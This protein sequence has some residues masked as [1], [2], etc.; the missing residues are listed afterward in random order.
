M[1]PQDIYT[2]YSPNARSITGYNAEEMLERSQY[3]FM[4]QDEKERVSAV[5]SDLVAARQEISLMEYPFIGRSG[6]IIIMERNGAP[7]LNENNVITGYRGIDRDITNR[8]LAEDHLRET[9][10][11]AS[12]GALAAGVAHEINNPLT[13]V[14]LYSELMLHEDVT[15]DLRS[16]MSAVHQAALRMS[17]IVKSLLDYARRSEPLIIE[18][19]IVSIIRTALNLKF[20][21]FQVNNITLIDDGV[22]TEDD[23][24][25]HVMSDE[26]QMLQVILNLLNNAEQACIS[27]QGDSEIADSSIKI[28]ASQLDNS[29]LVS[30]E[31]NGA[32]IAKDALP[33]I[34]EPFFTT[35]EVGQGTG[36]G[37]SVSQGIVALHHGE[38][39]AEN[40]PTGGSG[41]YIKLPAVIK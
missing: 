31:D 6:L 15:D 8:K 27:T 23:G 26:N 1:D 28:S 14:I 21:D 9:D 17:R 34:F 16:S 19:S 29:V 35:R 13:S 37:L 24:F 40:L 36:L 32:G 7:I 41:F 30:I 12:I 20:Y 10:R 4:P 18:T 5:F 3:D 25:P 22:P 38:I 11:L 39:W 2:Y 33:N